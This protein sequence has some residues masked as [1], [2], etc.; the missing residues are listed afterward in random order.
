MAEIT[1]I[2]DMNWDLTSYF[3]EFDGEEM[4]TFKG[5]LKAD[6]AALLEKASGVPELKVDNQE[7]WEAVFLQY[8]DLNARY[9]NSGSYIGCLTSVDAHNE[10]YSREEAEQ[11]RLG[12]EASKLMVELLRAV[13]DVSDDVFDQFVKREALDGAAYAIGRMRQDAQFTMDTAREALTAD[14]G[15]DGIQSWGRL[16]DTVSGKLEFEM[17]YPHGRAEKLPM[18]QRR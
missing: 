10:A 8:E 15:V 13:K 1:Q 14:L 16:Y 7:D 11:S 18:S 2:S 3:P 17:A 9:G 6:L 12:A 4:R 5:E